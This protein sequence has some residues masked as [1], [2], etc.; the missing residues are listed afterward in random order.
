MKGTM[1]EAAQNQTGVSA[2]DRMF[3]RIASG[4]TA[5]GLGTAFGAL[6]CLDWRS[7]G[8]LDFRWHWEA[9]VWI[10]IGIATAIYFWRSVWQ[11]DAGGR[12]GGMGLSYA[13]LIGATLGDVAYSLRSFP[14]EKIKDLYVGLG[15][16]VLALSITGW[17]I[18][19]VIRG[20]E[21][22]DAANRSGD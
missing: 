10:A 7:D 2:N 21:Q 4:S 3:R 17:L 22:N 13:L 14:H 5:L 19:R 16:A 6:A 15:A 18:S 8:G 20:F 12:R 1:A 9:L 11:V